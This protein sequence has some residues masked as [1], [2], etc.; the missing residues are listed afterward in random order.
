VSVA[1]GS[2]WNAGLYDDKYSFVWKIAAGLLDLL[3]AKPD[4]RILDL[5]CG[6]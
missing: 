6:T 1:Q 4:E 3:E 2:H 5:G